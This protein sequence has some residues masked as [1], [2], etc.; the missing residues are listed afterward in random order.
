[1]K[2]KYPSLDVGVN[3]WHNATLYLAVDHN[4]LLTRRRGKWKEVKYDFPVEK[5]IEVSTGEML[6]V[7]GITRQFYDQEVVGK[8]FVP[9]PLAS[10][11]TRSMRKLSTEEETQFWTLHRLHKKTIE[12]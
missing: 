4:L 9:I 11:R 3:Y 2:K 10:R 5:A 6:L 12:D 7:W 8:Y 1:M